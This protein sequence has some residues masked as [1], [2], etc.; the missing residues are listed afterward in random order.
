MPVSLARQIHAVL[1]GTPDTLPLDELLGLVD[2]FVMECASSEEPEVLIAHLEE[3]LQGVHHDVIDYS[4][5]RHAEIFLT[6]L[7]HLAPVIP[8]TSVISWFDLVLRPALREPR[9]ATVP[10]NYAKELIIQALKKSSDIYSDRIENYA[11][12]VAGFRKRL[13]DLYLLDAFNEGSENDILEWVELGEEERERRTRW[14]ENL[15][16]ILIKYGQENPEVDSRSLLP[17]RLL[18][19]GPGSFH[20]DSCPFREPFLSA[21]AIYAAESAF[22]SFILFCR[23]SRSIQT[24]APAHYHSIHLP[25]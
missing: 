11:D 7:R 22:F 6:V 16:D 10:V 9:L 3:E 18:M 17:T 5:L 20:R 14:K 8:S 12:R 25:R 19:Q 23:S 1:N 2:D 24:P 13:F 21:P 4:N 15:E